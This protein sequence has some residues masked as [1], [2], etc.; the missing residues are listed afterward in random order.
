MPRPSIAKERY[1]S[2]KKIVYRDKKGHFIKKTKFDRLLKEGRI[3]F[4]RNT[5]NNP[6]TIR[7]YSKQVGIQVSGSGGA[8][9]TTETIQLDPTADGGAG[10]EI[11]LV[12]RNERQRQDIIQRIL[13]APRSPKQHSQRNDSPLSVQDKFKLENERYTTTFAQ[14]TDYKDLE[15]FGDN[16]VQEGDL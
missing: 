14:R 2:G 15:T 10:K 11:H 6:T 7:Q 12:Y 4:T 9:Y 13:S 1:T 8:K 3:S 5:T 16:E